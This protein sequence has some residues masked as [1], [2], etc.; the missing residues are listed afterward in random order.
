VQVARELSSNE[1]RLLE[2]LLDASDIPDADTLGAQIPFA[3]VVEG[4]PNLPSYLHLSVSGASPAKCKDGDLPGGAIVED[5]V[6]AALAL[7]VLAIRIS[8]RRAH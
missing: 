6:I 3:Q 5:V 2:W 4:T 7:A 1:R 8:R